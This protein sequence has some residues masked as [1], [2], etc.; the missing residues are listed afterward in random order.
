MAL[1]KK[2]FQWDYKDMAQG[3]STSN[4]IPDGGFSPTTDQV[5]LTT[6]PG[7]MYQP[8]QS[9]DASTGVTGEMI[10]SCE[11]PTGSYSRLFAGNGVGNDNG[12]FW[13]MSGSYVMTQRG[14]T[15]SSHA[16]VF[17]RTDMIAFASEAYITSTTH[18]VRWS[19][20]GSSNTFNTTFYAFTGNASAP[21]PAIVFEGLAFFGDGNM[22]LR[23]DSAGSAPT[24]ILTFTSGLIIVALGIDPGSGRMLISTIGQPNLSDT[25]NS[26]ARVFF[27]NGFSGQTDRAVPVDDMITAFVSTQGALYAA[28]GQSLGQWNGSGVTF[29][30][31]MA[32]GFVST[33]LMY[34]F[35]FCSI[36]STLYVVE[37]SKII[38]YGPIQQKGQAM[39]YPAF[40][41]QPSG[42]NTDLVSIH[43]VGQNVIAMSYED[44]KFYTWDSLSI[45]TA[46]TSTFFTNPYEFD[47]EMWIRRVRVTYGAQIN[48]NV[49]PGSMRFYDE[50]GVVTGTNPTLFGLLDLRNTSGAAVAYKDFFF[51]NV[52]LKQMQVN[53]IMDT[54]NM[55]IKRISVYG[56]LADR[57]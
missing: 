19:S 32:I 33:Q 14:S 40:N 39:F 21:H 49:D 12:Y 55:G 50:E 4:V 25:V 44:S 37:R 11:D 9:V 1:G 24:A 18:I 15:D 2:I 28:Y 30:R 53:L 26:G 7:V 22:L 51:T 23:M 38:A 27:Y 29:L 31:H 48:N 3:M 36:G 56:E 34:K 42:V 57:P 54:S 43:Y 13:S 35:H 5:N 41:N 17:G 10:A 20:I 6:T 16:Y 45:S 8:A 52:K 46:G 47:D